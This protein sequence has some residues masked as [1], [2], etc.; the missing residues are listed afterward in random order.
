MKKLTLT[1]GTQET[2]GPLLEIP[3]LT[4]LEE[5]HLWSYRALRSIHGIERWAK[6]LQWLSLVDCK[7][8]ADLEPLISLPRLEG[9][10]FDE[11]YMPS[12]QTVRRLSSLRELILFGDEIIDLSALEGMPSLTVRVRRTQKVVGAHL[13]GEGSK[14][15]RI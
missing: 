6:T 12:L 7:Y 8:V 1:G 4:E 11:S 9:L 10:R 5:L 14:V 13:L 3:Q 2:L 15:V